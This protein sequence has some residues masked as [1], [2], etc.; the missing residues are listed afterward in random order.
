MNVKT[1]IVLVVLCAVALAAV[2]GVKWL[3]AQPSSAWSVGQKIA[4]GFPLNDVT[5]FT[6]RGADQAVTIARQGGIWV[7][8]DYYDY[9]AS[10]SKVADLLQQ[11]HG[12][13]VGQTRRVRG[14]SLGKLRLLGPAA[15]GVEEGTHGTALQFFTK[16][17]KPVVELI[18]GVPMQR[19]PDPG[20]PYGFGRPDGH[21][22]RVASATAGAPSGSET[23]IIVKD[24]LATPT[25][26]EAWIE[27]QVVNV[28]AES[29][30]E[31]TL[32]APGQEPVVLTRTNSTDGFAMAGLSSNQ[33][34]NAGAAQSLAGALGH[35]T[36][37]SVV[38]PSDAST[39]TALDT[40]WSYRVRVA[41]GT[42]Y[43]LTLADTNAPDAYARLQVA[44]DAA[45][46]EPDADDAADAAAKAEMANAR[47]SSWLY[48]LPGYKAAELRKTQADLIAAPDAPA[49]DEQDDDE[50]ADDEE[51]DEDMVVHEQVHEQETAPEEA[52]LEPMTVN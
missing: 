47:F 17:A 30:R 38:A 31:V 43:T 10:F 18:A 37:Q 36:I 33:A 20:N 5:R 21:Y 6:V 13:T 11:V 49:L 24:A 50:E 19:E 7:V 39:N 8:A 42:S 48:V 40:A 3:R 23:V 28:P 32:T 34:V 16:D 9:P 41:N 25:S 29:V 15:S 45:D 4:P 26:P 14:N 22:I 2:W 27:R 46:A 12:M 51:A 1:M 35:F 52:G 44:Y